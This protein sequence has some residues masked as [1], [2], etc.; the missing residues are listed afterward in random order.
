MVRVKTD[1]AKVEFFNHE[2]TQ[3]ECN[4]MQSMGHCCRMEDTCTLRT[5]RARRAQLFER[6]DT[7]ELKVM[8]GGCAG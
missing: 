2:E 8:K 3:W 6:Q 4:E 5:K 7:R 1:K